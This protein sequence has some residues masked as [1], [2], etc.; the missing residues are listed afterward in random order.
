VGAA[1]LQKRGRGE[2]GALFLVLLVDG[3]AWMFA[4]HLQARFLLPAAVPM[5]LLV[6][7]G[8]QG[9]N[10]PSEG[11]TLAG[12]R[13]FFGT[14]VA[15]HALCTVFLLLPEWRLF[16]GTNQQEG[17]PPLVQPI[18]ELFGRMLNVA[19][20]VKRPANAKEAATIKPEKVLLV[21]DAT[22]WRF[23]GPVEYCTVFDTN[24]FAQTLRTGDPHKTLAWL[25]E[26]GIRYIWID[27]MEVERLRRT[28]GF[29]D[30]VTKE[31]IARLKE[32]GIEDTEAVE[33][34]GITILRVPGK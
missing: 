6:G 12:V 21:G 4:T 18:G 19:A 27:G 28:Y 33:G 23:V 26:E 22:A 14:I 2:A 32:V 11:I 30:A 3:V 20:E 16:G 7:R 8:A 24:R 29:D 25:Q 34:T 17:K 13:I 5:A 31:A 1:F 15:A 10:G 9:S